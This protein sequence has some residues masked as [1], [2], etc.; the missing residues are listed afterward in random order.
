VGYIEVTNTA[1]DPCL[2]Q[3]L[4]HLVGD[5]DK[6]GPCPAAHIDISDHL[7]SLEINTL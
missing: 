5:I 6:F 1:R 3:N 2:F 4:L 7:H